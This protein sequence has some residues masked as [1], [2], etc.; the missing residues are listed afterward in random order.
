ML[1]ALDR[2]SIFRSSTAGSAMSSRRTIPA[3][4][5]DLT[6]IVG[7]DNPL[8][9]FFAQVERVQDDNDPRDPILLWIGSEVG[10][11]VQAE[12][13]AGPLAPYAKL[14]SELVEQ[15]RADR[16]AD[17]DHGPSLL[18]RTARSMFGGLS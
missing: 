4:A 10:E 18:Q 1:N 15:L 16:A 9:T 5:P 12:Q 8:S 3:R 2:P 13:L 6:V 14:T 7:W 11:V 17:A